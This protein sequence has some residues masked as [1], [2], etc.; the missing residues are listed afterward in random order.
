MGRDAAELLLRS[1]ERV[2]F[3]G[4]GRDLGIDMRALVV[5]LPGETPVEVAWDALVR[6]RFGPSPE[7]APAPD[8]RLRGTVTDR[9]GNHFTGAVV[10]NSQAVMESDLFTGRDA[11]DRE[12]KIPF[13]EIVRLDRTW[14]G[15]RVWRSDGGE[16]NLAGTGDAGRGHRGVI[17]SDPGLGRA[18]VEWDDFESLRIQR[19]AELPG[20]D[21]FEG[22]H[23]LRGTV[24]TRA[25]EIHSGFILW[26]ADET[27]SWEI[28]DGNVRDV[29]LDVEFGKIASIRRQSSRS[30][31]VTL[32]D[33]RAFDLEDS[34]DVSDGNRGIFVSALGTGEEAWVLVTWDEFQEVRFE[35]E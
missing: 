17:I 11:R 13:A 8:R 20:F 15:T 28:L 22:G 9:W 34:N 5:E 1:G 4:G 24:T 35:H 33:G 30:A 2:R 31:V 7:A 21:A 12:V 10:W 26:D 18:L 25:G 19:D 6:V 14:E 16:L 3:S 29:A 27:W 23:R 32:L